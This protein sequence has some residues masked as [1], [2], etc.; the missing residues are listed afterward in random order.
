MNGSIDELQ[1]QRLVDGAM[2]AEKRGRFL[3]SVDEQ[4]E[5]WREVA[6]AFVEEQIWRDRLTADSGPPEC[7][8]AKPVIV[9]PAARR[10]WSPV[11]LVT[12]AAA[13]LVVAALSFEIGQHRQRL[14]AP[15][16]TPRES[17]DNVNDHTDKHR[18]EETPEPAPVRFV[19]LNVTAPD[20]ESTRMVRVPIYE[21]D[22]M[23]E[24][25]WSPPPE[26]LNEVNQQLAGLGYRVNPQDRYITEQL[27]DGRK[28]VVPVR[29]WLLQS[30][31]Q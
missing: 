17:S 9:R 28:L 6:L 21:E 4:P 23:P 1:L 13:L 11:A 22:Q 7:T 29:Q 2:T 25:P 5:H 31:G 30:Y 15:G 8:D 12:T 18:V 27:A 10:T 16:E 3:A 14:A 19:R 20:G 24:S 26:D